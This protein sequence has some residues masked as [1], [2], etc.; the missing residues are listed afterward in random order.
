M[1]VVVMLAYTDR[2]AAA[3]RQDAGSDEGRSTLIYVV[4]DLCC[5]P[6]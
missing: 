1:A 3:Q 4:L 6:L 2:H 5:R